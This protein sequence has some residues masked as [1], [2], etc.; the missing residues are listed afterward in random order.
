MSLRIIKGFENFILQR[1]YTE[2]E[3]LEKF[4]GEILPVL[5]ESKFFSLLSGVFIFYAFIIIVSLCMIVFSI[6]I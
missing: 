5:Q 6:W 2:F 4:V 3:R 1:Q